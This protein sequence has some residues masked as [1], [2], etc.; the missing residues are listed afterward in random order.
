MDIRT[1]VLCILLS[2]LNG[3]MAMAQ[4]SGLEQCVRSCYRAVKDAPT[5]NNLSRCVDL[6]RLARGIG[7]SE[8]DIVAFVGERMATSFARY[9]RADISRLRITDNGEGQYTVRGWLL[10]AWQGIP[11]PLRV[12]IEY[13][14]NR[15]TLIEGSSLSLTLEEYLAER[16][17][18]RD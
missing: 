7:R 14:G 13:D 17:T 16:V 2:L 11:L 1:L 4:A 18:R 9:P 6:P 5:A 12:R 10:H 3:S 15:C 8:N